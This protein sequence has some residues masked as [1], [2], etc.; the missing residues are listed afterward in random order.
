MSI[1]THTMA[2]CLYTHTHTQRK[3]E[4]EGE[5]GYLFYSLNYNLILILF[6]YLLIQIVPT[7]VIEVFLKKKLVPMF[8]MSFW[9]ACI[10]FFFFFGRFGG[11]EWGHFL[12]FWDYKMFQAPL[13][14]LSNHRIKHLSKDLASFYCKDNISYVIW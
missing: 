5:Y 11:L 1:H 8:S 4:R 7:L 14:S 6:V 13:F 3:R 10:F 9:H 12:T 2:I